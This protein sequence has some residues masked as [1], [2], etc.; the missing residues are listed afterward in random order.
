M[1]I[2]NWRYVV[3][4]WYM[5]PNGNIVEERQWVPNTNLSTT[6]TQATPTVS[7]SWNYFSPA[8]VYKLQADWYY[9]QG[10][11]A[12]GDAF[13]SMANDLWAYSSYANSAIT[14]YDALLNYLRWNET[15]LQNASWELYNR[16]TSWIQNDYDYVNRMFWPDGELTREVNTYYDDLW[17][18]LATEAWR[19]AANI[20]A[21]WVHSWASLWSVRAQQ[22][23][24][25]NEAFGR[26]VQ[27]KEQQINAKQQI[28][29]NLINY[30]STLRREYWDTTNQYIIEMYKRANDLY[31]Q[32]AISLA[33]DL[34]Q[35]NTLRT[36]W[37]WSWWS[38]SNSL[39]SLWLIPRE[40][41]T[42]VDTNGNTYKVNTNWELELATNGWITTSEAQAQLWQ[43][44]PWSK[45]SNVN[46][47]WLEMGL[48]ALN[49]LG[50]A[51]V[52]GGNYL[53]NNLNR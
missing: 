42:Y 13:W 5:D 30:M 23:E 28:A 29:T 9:N 44:V 22:N 10:D 35:F 27:A 48:A 52:K 1:A 20:A 39:S 21:Q 14:W 36:S 46:I 18:Y 53:D 17:N 26:Y 8:D 45:A 24:A 7:P 12:L 43:T 51:L 16:L 40:N 41:W 33:N 15:W 19:Q 25:Y 49:P 2:N 6:Q 11:T 38:S 34:N 37:S 32:T 4:W 50:Y 47:P 31:N 3:T